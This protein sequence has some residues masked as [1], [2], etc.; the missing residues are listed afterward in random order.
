MLLWLPQLCWWTR[1]VSW[2]CL[3]YNP[4]CLR[5]G[6]GWSRVGDS[7]VGCFLSQRFWE[8]QCGVIM[9]VATR[10]FSSGIRKVIALKRYLVS[11]LIRLYRDIQF[12]NTAKPWQRRRQAETT[13]G[14]KGGK[15][16]SGYPPSPRW[17]GQL[18]KIKQKRFS[19]CKQNISAITEIPL[20][21]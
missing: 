17:G 13:R 20:T 15:I 7:W 10:F 6:M 12:S 4:S 5:C 1:N 11:N 8:I 18:L 14:K 9:G 3:R 16:R 2:A 21:P 19:K